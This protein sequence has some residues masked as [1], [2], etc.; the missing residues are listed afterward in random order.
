MRPGE[1]LSLCQHYKGIVWDFGCIFTTEY[2][3]IS[4]HAN[5]YRALIKSFFKVGT[6]DCRNCVLDLDWAG[7]CASDNDECVSERIC[8]QST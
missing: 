2:H 3:S 5:R 4:V 7:I 1:I 8:S 6:N